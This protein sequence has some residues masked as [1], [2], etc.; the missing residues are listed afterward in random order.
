MKRILTAIVLVLCLLIVLGGCAR[1]YWADDADYDNRAMP[2]ATANVTASP[3]G[4]DTPALPR[5][6]RGTDR[7]TDANRNMGRT[8]TNRDMPDRNRDNN[9]DRTV[10]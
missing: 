3:Q 7:D 10:T 6:T 1:T 4:G 2:R 8:G 9:T 5:I